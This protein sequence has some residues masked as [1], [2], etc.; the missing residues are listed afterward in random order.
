[1]LHHGEAVAGIGPIDH[2]AD[3]DTAQSACPT[4]ARFHDPRAFDTHSIL[5][6]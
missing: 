4:L 5:Y 3:P 6:P 2:E 1:M